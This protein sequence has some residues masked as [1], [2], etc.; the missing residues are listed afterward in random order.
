MGSRCLLTA[1]PG[2][3]G[4]VTG[5][6]CALVA[7]LAAVALPMAGPAAASPVTVGY[8]DFSY[9]TTVTAPTGMKPE[10]KLWY[11][12]DNT[13]WGVLWN[14]SSKRFEIYRF[15]KVGQSWSTT[16]TSVDTRRVSE[17]DTL[18]DG[19]A[20][21]LYV[22][23]HVKDTNTATDLN[24]KFSRYTYASGAYTLDSG[25]PVNIANI[26]PETAVFDKDTTGTFWL[27]FTQPNGAGGRKV[28][29]AHSTTGATAWTAPYD[30]AVA[31]A[32]NL[33]TD[34]ISTLVAFKGRTGVL[35]GNEADGTLNFAAHVDGAPDSSWTARVLCDFNT[36]GNN[37]CPDDHFNIKS[38]DADGTGRV[39]AIVKTSLNDLPTSPPTAPLE[40]M[41]EYIPATNAWTR[42]TVWTVADNVTRAITL[43]DTTNKVV[44][45]F[46]AA[47]CCSGGTVYL[48]KSSYDT[49]SFGSGLGTPFL[50]SST[51]PSINNVTSTKQSVNGST[52]LLVEAG[53]D[54]TRFY[55]HNFLSLSGAGDITP[56][57]TT[58]DSGPSGTVTG[59]SATFAFSSSEAGS[60]FACALDGAAFTSCASPTSYSGL[61]TGSHTFGVRA[62][63]AAG[64]TDPT[65]ATRTWTVAGSSSI[66]DLGE[67]GRA[68]A[69][70]SGTTLTLTTTQAVAA[71]R[72]V[73]LG[74]GYSSAPGVTVSAKDSASN[75]YT[76]DARKDNATSTGTTGAVVSSTLAAPLPSGSTITLTVSAT[77]TYRLAVAYAYSGITAKDQ[78]ATATGTST[79]PSSGT[80]A[81][82][83]AANE[84][85]F[86]VTVY[87]SGTA[88]HTAGPGLTELVELHAGTKGLAI[89]ERIVAATGSYV[90][91][92]TLSSSVIWTDSMV[93]YR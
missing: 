35:W 34:E 43:L 74:A 85:V 38:L 10:S 28:S 3:L 68:T 15:D 79:G 80:T 36:Y 31:H 62:T 16:G 76:V 64:N 59:T 67:I 30:L 92:G 21:K 51:D 77:V 19:S 61:A 93:T 54:S 25:F 12:Q 89:D 1:I 33:G 63:D 45:A 47:P 39:F 18:F 78:S 60:N 2:G 20:S 69:S 73:V 66:A 55:L 65:P 71:G 48:K 58:I 14:T 90:D 24:I 29:I 4:L 13:W 6:V 44:Y 17:A 56:P 87:G 82:T 42:T 46:A 5:L 53:D 40:V 57:E 8:R 81:T 70:T 27:T 83:A 41:Y 84:L 9:G 11:T 22:M 86:G 72:R 75:S 37:K 26:N 23:S 49:L 32:G 50:R 88:G 7:G 91:S 52:G